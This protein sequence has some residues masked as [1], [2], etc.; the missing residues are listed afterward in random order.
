MATDTA[1]GVEVAAKAPTPTAAVATAVT[2]ATGDGSTSTNSSS[3]SD[4]TM[5]N[6]SEA[7]SGRWLGVR[8]PTGTH[9][10]L[11]AAQARAAV[12]ARL[13]AA[14]KPPTPRRKRRKP[15][16]PARARRCG[17]AVVLV[18]GCAARAWAPT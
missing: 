15:R 14:R 3:A 10:P 12:E 6:L 7:G 16:G 4:G 8:Y 1:L 11:T 2:A 17:S 5:A 13:K 9:G 18:P